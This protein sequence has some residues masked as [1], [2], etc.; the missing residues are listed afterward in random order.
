MQASQFWDVDGWAGTEPSAYPTVWPR[1][2]GTYTN[3]TLLTASNAGLPLGDLNAFP[4]EKAIYEYNRSKIEDHILG[5]NT[6]QM[7]DIELPVAIDEKQLAA[8]VSIYPN[9]VNNILNI[10]S[11]VAVNNVEIYS[12][13]GS[14][15]HKVNSSRM[16]TQSI[17]ISEL[18]QGM[19]IVRLG[20]ENGE[21]FSSK[22]TKK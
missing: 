1:W 11:T 3:A 2:N 20:F 9:P 6:D 21:S 16:L 15:V 7:T 5:L 17:D 19:Y 22:L 14:L 13:T 10:E 4:E 18:A 8:G 12:I